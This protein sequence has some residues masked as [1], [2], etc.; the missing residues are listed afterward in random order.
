MERVSL[1]A[2]SR[3]SGGSIVAACLAVCAIPGVASVVHTQPAPIEVRLDV[4][5]SAEDGARLTGLSVADFVV[6]EDGIRQTVLA[7]ERAPQAP[8]AWIVLLD[9]SNSLEGGLAQLQRLAGDL[10]TRVRPRHEVAVFGFGPQLRILQDFTTDAAALT[11][12]ITNARQQGSTSLYTTLYTVLDYVEKRA[13]GTPSTRY[14]LVV[15]S[16]GKDTSSV[17]SL[18]AALDAARRAETVVYAIDADHSDRNQGHG[19]LRRFAWETGGDVLLPRAPGDLAQLADRLVADVASRY[20][21][22]YR[23]TNARRDGKFR[24]LEVKVNR[25]GAEVR[26]RSGYLAPASR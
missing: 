8:I 1:A 25:P 23:S 9:T 20:T 3:V 12:A 24:R 19:T 18:D 11:A 4:V 14:V 17:V 21:L 5:V 22:Q 7:A 10:V 26:T 15:L 16:D 2:V 13:G 6:N